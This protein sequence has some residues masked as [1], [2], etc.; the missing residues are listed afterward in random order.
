MFIDSAPLFIGIY[1]NIDSL[2]LIFA[3]V[4]GFVYLI[5][6]F[7]S[8][9]VPSRVKVG[10][11]FIVA[12]CIFS[13]GIATVPNPPVNAIEFGLMLSKEII[14]GM[15]LG[16][17][18]YMFFTVFHLAGQ[19]MDY[20]IGFSMANVLDPVSGTQVPITGDLISHIMSVLIIITGGLNVLIATFFESYKMI[21]IGYANLTMNQGFMQYLVD[22][23]ANY[24][25]L[26]IRIAAPILGTIL[27]IDIAL[28]ILVKAT[29]QMNVF[30]VGMPI[31]LLV[32]L[33]ILF[34]VC[35]YL[36]DVYKEIFA[37]IYDSITTIIGG[38]AYQ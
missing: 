33:I 35:P 38:M 19:M 23:S 11:S 20:S 8:T 30:V 25:S 12:M 13:S 5:P 18:V 37:I 14:T 1:E 10:F 27:I 4:V 15:I 22:I 31:K 9:N 16:F 26:G 7:A 28:G 32:G 34:V 29:P 21:P 17:V 6:I 24:L 36:I 2:M 3:R